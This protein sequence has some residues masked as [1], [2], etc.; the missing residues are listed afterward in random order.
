MNSNGIL[1]LHVVIVKH[2]MSTGSSIVVT[3]RVAQYC[4][5]KSLQSVLW[6]QNVESAKCNIIYKCKEKVF[7]G[8]EVAMKGVVAL[9]RKQ[10]YIVVSLFTSN[11]TI[12]RR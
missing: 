5:Y 9:E 10:N 12:K 8:Y 1:G 7:Y 4:V 6:K 2:N 3:E 11:A